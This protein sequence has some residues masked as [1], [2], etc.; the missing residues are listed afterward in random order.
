MAETSNEETMDID[1]LNYLHDGVVMG[2]E[3]DQN[4][5]GRRV[6][7]IHTVC[8]PDAEYPPW[9]GRKIV[10]I[11]D[12]VVTARHFIAGYTDRSRDWISGWESQISQ[13][14]KTDIEKLES[15]GLRCA[16]IPFEVTF[17]SGSRLEG[18]C[19]AIRVSVGAKAMP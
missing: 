10:V 13:E 5:D 3:L 11:L 12:G 4:P 9:D 6:I 8:H 14:I 17:Q 18:L 19:E 16:G 7:R 15:V 2:I 1:T